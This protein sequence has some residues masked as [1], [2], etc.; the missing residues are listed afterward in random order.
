MNGNNVADSVKYRKNDE[1]IG[2]EF[3]IW[4]NIERE[5]F[6]KTNELVNCMIDKNPKTKPN[7]KA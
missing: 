7:R 4:V 1:N 5:L 3:G 2:I 6:F